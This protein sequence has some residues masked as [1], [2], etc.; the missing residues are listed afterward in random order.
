[1]KKILLS[2]LLLAMTIVTSAQEVSKDLIK[3]AKDGDIEAQFNLGK[4]YVESL[5]NA[6]A[7]KWLYSAA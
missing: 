5:D 1:M 7:A 4:A 3:K 6:Q 2:S